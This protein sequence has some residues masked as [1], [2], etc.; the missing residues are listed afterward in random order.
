M[1]L[2]SFKGFFIEL[3]FIRV[4]IFVGINECMETYTIYFNVLTWMVSLNGIKIE[5]PFF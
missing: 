1:A 4:Q 2:L 5:I 3:L